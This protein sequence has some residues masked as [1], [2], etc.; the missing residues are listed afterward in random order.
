MAAAEL[1][2]AQ[3]QEA[4]DTYVSCGH[5]ASDAA[6]ALNIS[7]GAFQNRMRQAKRKGMKP[8][9]KPPKP[10]PKA[11]APEPSPRLPISADECWGLLDAWIGR[12]RIP[13]PKPPKWK[14]KD[15]QRIVVA[16]DFHAPF[17]SPEAVA[18][19]IAR[20][21]KD[22]D[23]LIINGDLS[24][25]YSISR[26]VKYEHVP[27]EQEIAAVDALL[28]TLAGAFPDVVIV[29]GNHDSPRFEK[30]LRAVL[31]PDLM[32]CVEYLTGGN[33][34]IIKALARR[35]SNVRFAPI[36]VGRFDVSWA[37]QIGDCICTH[38]EKFSKVPGS[39]LRGIDE[40]LTDQRMTLG[41]PDYR[42][43]VQA[44]THQGA[45]IPWESD[46]LLVE[47]GAMCEVHG[48]QLSARIAG[49]PQRRG[50]VVL[51]QHKGVTDLNSVRFVWLDPVLRHIA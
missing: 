10:K 21:A 19:L 50:Y 43:I 4:V 24:D 48:Y 47:G 46:K 25:G 13:T 15:W 29:D 2:D 38:A 35:H 37:T 18:E 28:T 40:W 45:V 41:L 49:R 34:S 26:F 39:A 6:D 33:L 12:K 8:P 20:E 30:Q 51:E 9:P 31:T 16:S 7:R 1:S 44:H 3:L 32:Y 11:K 36:K 22:A 42:V 27:M 5:N 23:T 17:H 14:A